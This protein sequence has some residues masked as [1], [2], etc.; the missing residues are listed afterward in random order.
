MAPFDGG[1]T[2]EVVA[3]IAGARTPYLDPFARGAFVGLNVR[4]SL[5]HLTRAVMEGVT[6]SLKDCLDLISGLQARLP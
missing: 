5:A 6:Y 2:L 1:A 3:Y 4:H